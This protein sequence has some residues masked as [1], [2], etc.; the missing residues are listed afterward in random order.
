L[1]QIFMLMGERKIIFGEHLVYSPSE[2]LKQRV[3][4]KGSRSMAIGRPIPPLVLSDN[5]V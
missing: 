2:K 4:T 3:S 5:E 1:L